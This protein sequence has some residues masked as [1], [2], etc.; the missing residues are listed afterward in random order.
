MAGRRNDTDVEVA[1]AK[2]RSCGRLAPVSA[3]GGRARN[4]ANPGC[5]CHL[6]AGTRTAEEARQAVLAHRA[7]KLEVFTRLLRDKTV[8]LTD[9][10]DAALEIGFYHEPEA[11]A[12]L[13]AVATDPTEDE[14]LLATAGE[15]A[16]E[17][18]GRLGRDGAEFADRLTPAARSEFD[19]QIRGQ[20]R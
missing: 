13:V 17:I 1:Q 4:A 20:D 16:G 18:C 11:L 6:D 7:H 19:A 8:G 12:A 10:D 2:P 14:S 15:M 3:A 9:R 5:R